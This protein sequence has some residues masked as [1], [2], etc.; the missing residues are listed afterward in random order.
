[1]KIGSK[2]DIK[3]TPE[4]VKEIIKKYFSDRYTVNSVRFDCDLDYG[5][6]DQGHGSPTFMGAS[7]TANIDNKED[8][9]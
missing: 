4:E 8:S 1:M 2:I 9:V 3:L 7:V 5:Q 6:F